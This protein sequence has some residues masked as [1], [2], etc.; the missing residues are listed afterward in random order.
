MNFKKDLTIYGII[1]IIIYISLLIYIHYLLHYKYNMFRGFKDI[2]YIIWYSTVIIQTLYF[3][4]ILYNP[5]KYTKSRFGKNIYNL[6]TIGGYNSF[7]DILILSEKEPLYE[8]I[9]LFIFILIP[10]PILKNITYKKRI[11]LL[12]SKIGLFHLISSLVL[13]DWKTKDVHLNYYN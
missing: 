8:Y 9:Y 12:L 13:L 5:E 2:H 10:F 3:C 1:N 11:L 4:M 7:K 6:F